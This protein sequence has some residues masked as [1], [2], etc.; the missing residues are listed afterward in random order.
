MGVIKGVNSIQLRGEV[1]NEVCTYRMSMVFSVIVSTT[2]HPRGS[3]E[4]SFVNYLFA[5]LWEGF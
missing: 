3:L 1:Q 4:A 5:H 2:K